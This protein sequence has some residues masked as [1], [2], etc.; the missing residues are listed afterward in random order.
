MRKIIFAAATAMAL[1]TGSALADCTV[2]QLTEK[3]KIF[4]EKLT[5]LSQKSAQKAS[6]ISQKVQADSAQTPAKS[7]DDSCKKY[8]EWNAMIDKA[9]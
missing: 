1:S 9:N 2:E 4:G 7:L 8:D 3:T 6:E 5:A